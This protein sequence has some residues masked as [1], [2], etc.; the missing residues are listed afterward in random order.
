L[1]FFMKQINSNTYNIQIIKVHYDQ[2]F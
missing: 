2:N 1:G